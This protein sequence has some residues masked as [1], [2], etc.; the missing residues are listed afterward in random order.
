MLFVID[1]SE[2]IEEKFREQINFLRR[3][4]D[5]VNVHPD[6]VRVAVI[7]YAAKSS[8]DF[9]FKRYDSNESLR[10][11]ILS[12][13]SKNTTTRTDLALQMALDVFNGGQQNGMFF[14]FPEFLAF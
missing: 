4:V 13:K 3:V 9:D 5:N 12:L 8:L 1:S 6:A 10:Q 7:T 14:Y 2:S 11:G